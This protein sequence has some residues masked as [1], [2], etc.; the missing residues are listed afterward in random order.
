MI[1]SFAYYPEWR[2]RPEDSRRLFRT[3]QLR[4][5]EVH[6]CW[7]YVP[8]KPSTLKRIL[9]E[10]S[11]VFFSWLKVMLLPRP[12]LYVVVSPPLLLGAAAWLAGLLKRAPFVFH[13]QD[14]QP[15]A[16]QMLGMVKRGALTRALYQLEA[17]AYRHASL[18]SGITPGM[19]RAFIRKGVPESK[20]ALFPNGIDLPTANSLPR[21]GRFRQRFGIGEQEF[22]ATY[23][24]NLGAKHGV[25][26]LLDAAQ[27]LRG[28]PF[29]TVICGD[30]AQREFLERR[31]R[32]LG[33]GNVLFLPLQSEAEYCEMMV[34]TD[35]Y[36]VT[37][38][39]GS[40]ALFFPSK[41]LKGLAFSRAII[42][43]ADGESELTAAA[44]EG[45]FAVVVT[46]GRPEELARAQERLASN[47]PERLA[48][49]AAGRSFVERF[50]MQHVLATFEARLA[51]LCEAPGEITAARVVPAADAK[52]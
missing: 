11:F 24:G 17:F 35:A 51:A 30:G 18:V 34:D 22:V 41:L 25:E 49:G 27:L 12:D 1:T 9:H 5:V 2:K 10:L 37:Q 3:D 23:S 46:P 13:V 15:D 50:E 28:R 42:V 21:R 44:V 33:L 40:G 47:T 38:Q 7:H 39:A 26:I 48:L 6:R 19:T 32:D 36:F 52:N 4:G 8:Q 16:A 14:L 20:V 43:V 31:A 29:R 45:R